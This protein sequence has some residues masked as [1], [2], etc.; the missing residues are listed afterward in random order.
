V[1]GWIAEARTK[2][3]SWFR[4]AVGERCAVLANAKFI[5]NI[6]GFATNR[7]WGVHRFAVDDILRIDGSWPGF[8]SAASRCQPNE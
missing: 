4:Q 6:A 3:R 1:S 7:R 2:F 8:A 5:A